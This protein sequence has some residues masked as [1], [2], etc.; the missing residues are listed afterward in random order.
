MPAEYTR[1]EADEIERLLG[2]AAGAELLTSLAGRGAVVELAARAYRVTGADL[3]PECLG[4]ARSA[5]VDRRV[6][7]EQ[8]DMRD[9][10]WPARFDAAF[11][12]GNSFGYLEDEGDEAFLR[13]VAAVLKPGG[14]FV[15]E[16]PM[17]I[18][19]RFCNSRSAPGFRQAT[20]I[21]S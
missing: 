8:R 12:F 4:H 5:D 3:P 13:S 11:C 9:L 16:T 14:K 17:V 20:S 2:V 19:S 15:L 7:W 6:A 18:E 1:N 21:C 10:P